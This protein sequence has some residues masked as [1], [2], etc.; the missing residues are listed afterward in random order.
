MDELKKQTAGFPKLFIKTAGIDK[1]IVVRN[2]LLL[3]KREVEHGNIKFG[4]AG[5]KIFGHIQFVK[6]Q[7]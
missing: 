1:I 4:N 3:N 5:T 2:K 6:S 7:P